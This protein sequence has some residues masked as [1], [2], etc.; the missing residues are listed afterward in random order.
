MLLHFPLVVSLI[1]SE[2]EILCEGDTATDFDYTRTAA[3]LGIVVFWEC[4]HSR[5]TGIRTEIV[6]ILVRLGSSRQVAGT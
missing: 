2:K 6:C 1:Y 5:L 4:C 3:W